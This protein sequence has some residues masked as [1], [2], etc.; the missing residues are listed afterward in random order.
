MAKKHH[1]VYKREILYEMLTSEIRI[2]NA[3]MCLQTK[4]IAF[5][6]MHT[7]VAYYHLA[8]AVVVYIIYT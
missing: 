6:L 5:S 4:I 3:Y 1:K 2:H 7:A 8:T